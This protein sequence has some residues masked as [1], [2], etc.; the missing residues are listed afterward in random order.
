MAEIIIVGRRKQHIWGN[1]NRVCKLLL[2]QRRN[3][4]SKTK[5]LNLEVTAG[6]Y[7]SKK[8]IHNIWP[9]GVL[10]LIII[11]QFTV[12]SDLHVHNQSKTKYMYFRFKYYNTEN[13][14]K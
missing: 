8:N 11:S 12:S 5:I 10:K 6:A 9:I 1:K 13:Q 3:H 7:D 14:M 4:F 2:T